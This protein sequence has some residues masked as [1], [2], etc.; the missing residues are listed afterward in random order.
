M[1]ITVDGLL[2]EEQN[3][4][5]GKKNVSK[6][7]VHE[8]GCEVNEAMCKNKKKKKKRQ[9]TEKTSKSGNASSNND[10][11]AKETDSQ[12]MRRC[13]RKKQN[14]GK[15]ISKSVKPSESSNS[16][17]E[18]NEYT[19]DGF[20]IVTSVPEDDSDISDAFESCSEEEY[21][22]GEE[23]DTTSSRRETEDGFKIVTEIPP[24][25]SDVSDAFEDGEDDEC[26]DTSL[27]SQ[28]HNVKKPLLQ[29][30]NDFGEY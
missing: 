16:T 23:Q 18:A 11:Y 27:S 8:N 29:I 17:T 22:I 6:K 21:D 7:N 13:E 5:R 3:N 19:D 24:D 28:Q 20:K 2:G 15:R 4:D 30:M 12:M 9:S 26:T 25:D 14:T 1:N 10:P